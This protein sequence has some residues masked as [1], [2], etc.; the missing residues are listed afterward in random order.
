[1]VRFKS[2]PTPTEGPMFQDFEKF[3]KSKIRCPKNFN[4]HQ[5][6]LQAIYYSKK[7]ARIITHQARDITHVLRPLKNTREEKS[8]FLEISFGKETENIPDEGEI[9]TE[10]L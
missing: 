7:H 4:V 3:E 1:M 6:K 8:G 2:K 9:I 5:K 10:H